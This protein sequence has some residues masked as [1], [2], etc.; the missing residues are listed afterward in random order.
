MKTCGPWPIGVCSW[1]LAHDNLAEV[2]RGMGELGLE[3]IHLSLWP[4]IAE[5]KTAYLEQARSQKWSISSTMI[6]FAHE[7]YT[8]LETI[9][10]SGG[11][12]PDEHWHDD[13]LVVLQAINL[14]ADLG[15]PYLS[16]HAGFIDHTHQG[17]YRQMQRRMRELA[18][19]AGEHNLT[20][21]METGQETAEDLRR[22]LEEL[23]HPWLGVNFDPANMILYGKG[24]PAD[25]VETLGPWIRHVHIKDARPA[26]AP[27]VWGQEV[28]WG[29]GKVDQD[30]FL[31]ALATIDFS[32]V[33]AIERE[34][35]GTRMADIRQAIENLTR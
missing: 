28:A 15:A 22:F 27:G 4:V 26:P 23:D 16:F 14:T 9:R 5:K 34:A 20:L 3:H 19:A 12:V 6:G 25:A 35:G 8:S 31:A 29:D 7:N 24:N 1:S 21:L 32:G 30:E 17:K 11:I 33:M 2:A 13:R 10:Q 18:D